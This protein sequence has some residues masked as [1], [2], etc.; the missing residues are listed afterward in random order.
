M[1]GSLA[2]PW[3]TNESIFIRRASRRYLQ[4]VRGLA[5]N[6]L[7]KFG[8]AMIVKAIVLAAGRGER[9]RPLTD[10]TP[11]PLLVVGGKSLIA[12]HLEALARA[13]VRDVVINLSWLGDRIREQLSDGA[14][15][16]VRITYSDEGPLALETGG[17]VFKALPLLGEDAFLVIS[18]D[19]WTDYPFADLRL[20]PQ[21]VAHFVLVPN[22]SFHPRGDFGLSDGR[23]TDAEPRFTYANIAVLRPEFFAGS[24]PGRFAL[25]PLMFDWIRKGRV[26]AEVYHGRWHNLGTPAQ[27]AEL[28]SSLVRG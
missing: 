23:A 13:G 24:K 7:G 5:A 12:Y 27:L 2:I 8:E 11:K 10:T 26:S 15:Y 6:P 19:I 21:D 20:T 16:G 3:S 4:G 22:P 18:G 17:G 25:G 9:M 14:Q 28:G 1:P